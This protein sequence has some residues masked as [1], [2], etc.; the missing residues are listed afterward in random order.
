MAL[1]FLIRLLLDW[2]EEITVLGDV[3]QNFYF[4]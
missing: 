1:N 4:S 2:G 3:E